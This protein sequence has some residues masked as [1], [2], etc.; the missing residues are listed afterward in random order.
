MHRGQPFKVFVPVREDE[1]VRGLDDE[2][3]VDHGPAEQ[4]RIPETSRLRLIEENQLRGSKLL[5]EIGHALHEL[6]VLLEEFQES[7]IRGEVVFD[8]PLSPPDDDVEVPDSGGI[9]L[10]ENRLDERLEFQRVV[11]AMGDDWQ[12]LLGDLLGEREQ[13][14]PDPA[15]RDQRGILVQPIRSGRFPDRF[16]VQIAHPTW[17]ERAKR[18][19]EH[20][21]IMFSTW[22]Q[23]RIRAAFEAHLNTRGICVDH[24]SFNERDNMRRS[25]FAGA[26]FLRFSAPM[27]YQG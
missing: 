9:E 20:V 1:R 5:V 12:H 3:A 26:L 25:V 11:P 10:L 23:S 27:C 15:R 14:G 8:R 19:E 7:R 16:G 2:R 24:D 22:A 17:F 4:D 6:S 13:S 18:E 21:N